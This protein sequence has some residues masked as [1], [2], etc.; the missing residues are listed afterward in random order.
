MNNKN[1]SYQECEIA[2][3]HILTIIAK[4]TFHLNR[5]YS[6]DNRELKRPVLFRQTFCNSFKKL[7]NSYYNQIK[8]SPEKERHF[9]KFKQNLMIEQGLNYFNIIEI[10]KVNLKIMKLC[11]LMK[12]PYL[13]SMCSLLVT[14]LFLTNLMNIFPNN[15]YCRIVTS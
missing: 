4:I 15:R 11:F 12:F 6:Q 14:L 13:Q 9:H 2:N 8:S 7:H 10:F 5:K 3:L 1:Y